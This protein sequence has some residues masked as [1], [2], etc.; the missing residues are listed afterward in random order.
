MHL[1][2]GYVLVVKVLA[3]ENEASL[4]SIFPDREY[5]IFDRD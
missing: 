5:V 2:L 3:V 1:G 4:A